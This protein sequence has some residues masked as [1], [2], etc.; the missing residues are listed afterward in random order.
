MFPDTK[1]CAE[2]IVA[3]QWLISKQIKQMHQKEMKGENVCKTLKPSAIKKWKG[4]INQR[5]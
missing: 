2:I 1:A 5:H 4:Q 3:Y